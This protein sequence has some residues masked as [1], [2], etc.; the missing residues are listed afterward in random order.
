MNNFASRVLVTIVGVPVVLYLVYLGGWWLFGLAV[1]ASLVALHELYVMGRG[2]RPLVLAGYAGALATLLGAQLGGAEWMVGGF[3][4]TLVLAFLLYG[5]ADTRQTA[6]VT[7]SVTVLGVAWI[8][9]G[10]GHL[11]LLRDLPDHGRLAVFTVLLAVFADDTAAYLVG[12]LVGRH[13]LAPSLS[14]GKTWEGFLAGTAAAI[15]VAFFALY[16]QD[17]LTIPESI[18]FGAAIA[19]AG[20]AGDLFESALKRD[21]QVKDSGQLLGGHGG[22]LDRIDSLLFASVAA[23][24]VVIAVA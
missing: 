2:L 24:Y 20:A 15:A 14:P 23:F 16:G 22:M 19:L 4:V 18:G 3:M 13:K 11:L 12:R 6:T 7:M 1:L 10:L 9:L 21:L 5:I 17:F 8:S